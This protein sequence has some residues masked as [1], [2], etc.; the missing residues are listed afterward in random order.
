M[1]FAGTFVF[2]IAI[3]P[4]E[5]NLY[6]TDSVKHS[7]YKVRLKTGERRKLMQHSGLQPLGVALDRKSR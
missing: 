7:V 5:N 3:D 4:C 6:Y 1:I 2:G